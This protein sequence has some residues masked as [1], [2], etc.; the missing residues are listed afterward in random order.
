M[1][2]QSVLRVGNGR[3]PWPGG[4]INL[5]SILDQE[6]TVQDVTPPDVI[7]RDGSMLAVKTCGPIRKNLIKMDILSNTQAEIKVRRAILFAERRRAKMCG[8]GDARV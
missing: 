2:F 4:E 7:V 3:C 5:E 1:P 6:R 8:T